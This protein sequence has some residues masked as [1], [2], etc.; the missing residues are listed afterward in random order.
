MEASSQ[1]AECLPTIEGEGARGAI[2]PRK[3]GFTQVTFLKIVLSGTDMPVR[4]T[5]EEMHKKAKNYFIAIIL[6]CRLD[7]REFL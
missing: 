4:S 3:N 5:L 7:P 6:H 2:N 1:Q